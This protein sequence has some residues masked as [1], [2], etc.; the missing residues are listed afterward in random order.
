MGPLKNGLKRINSMEEKKSQNNSKPVTVLRIK[1][2]DLRMPFQ[3]LR[4]DSAPREEVVREQ[5]V[6]VDHNQCSSTSDEK[7]PVSTQKRVS[8]GFGNESLRTTPVDKI[9]SDSNLCQTDLI[10][11]KLQSEK[12]SSSPCSAVDTKLRAPFED[13]SSSGRQQD[14]NVG[15]ETNPSTP[16][17][18]N[19]AGHV[20]ECVSSPCSSDSS[21]D[22]FTSTVTRDKIIPAIRRGDFKK[23]RRPFKSDSSLPS[24]TES[25]ENYLDSEKSNWKVEPTVCSPTVELVTSDDPK[26][27]LKSD[28]C[29]FQVADG[30]SDN[31]SNSLIV[32][33]V[34][35][36]TNTCRT[37]SEWIVGEGSKVNA[38]EES[39]ESVSLNRTADKVRDPS[40]HHTR[41]E[42]RALKSSIG[43][44]TLEGAKAVSLHNE[45]DS[46]RE[47]PSESKT[48]PQNTTNLNDT[49]KENWRESCRKVSSSADFWGS[50]SGNEN[51]RFN[52]LV[53]VDEATKDTA[54]SSSEHS[55]RYSTGDIKFERQDSD[56]KGLLIRKKVYYYCTC[57]YSVCTVSCLFINCL[58]HNL[59]CSVDLHLVI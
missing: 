2:S 39:T 13:I 59:L 21:D 52:K 3:N 48:Q 53:S 15:A 28:S 18:Y 50:D 56:E 19:S 46:W 42:W 49:S 11:K 6:L 1:E 16:L 44:E 31:N 41:Q 36:G 33:E 58:S 40:T 32:A 12:L 54:P 43:D 24:T 8:V 5:H 25:L 20:V 30:V 22:V 38:N 55:K 23:A 45:T 35:H 4:E 26:D 47:R 10:A 51:W 34:D 9:L 29:S 7:L 57:M 37:S 17:S 27:Q 14:M